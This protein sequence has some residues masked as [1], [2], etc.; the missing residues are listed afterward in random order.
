MHHDMSSNILSVNFFFTRVCNYQCVYCLHT[1]T[2]S[3]MLSLSKMQQGLNLLR[4]AGMRKITFT[5]GEPFLFADSYLGPLVKFCKYELA[6]ESVSIVSNGSRV[7]EDWLNQHKGAI[8]ILAVSC[9]SF[10][11]ITN[12]RL[13]RGDGSITH[14]ILTIAEW[15]RS[16]AIC[17]KLNTVVN[18]LNWKEDMNAVLNRIR[19]FRWKCF[20]LLVIAGEN[21]GKPGDLRDAA[22]LAITRSQFW[23]F[24]KRHMKQ[25]SIVPEDNRLM[26]TSYLLLDEQMRFLDCSKGSK[27][28]S[29]SIFAIGV[30]E[31]MKLSGFDRRLFIERGGL[32]KWGRPRKLTEQNNEEAF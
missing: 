18:S 19:P 25:S 10:S 8:D 12:K 11:Q 31:A 2:T 27:E 21:E 7:T 6:L 22:P 5:G 3:Y 9:D 20:Q 26:R 14:R 4:E 32:Y 16:N 23:R 30:H 1:Q 28:P 17:F 15:C 13:G 29:D 24:I